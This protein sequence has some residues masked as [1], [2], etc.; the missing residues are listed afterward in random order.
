MGSESNK[1]TTFP[2]SI[3]YSTCVYSGIVDKIRWE[4]EYGKEDKTELLE[5][6]V[7]R[8]TD[9]HLLSATYLQEELEEYKKKWK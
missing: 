5:Y 2:K 3:E 8:Y 1:S 6:L 7:Q 9:E 4:K